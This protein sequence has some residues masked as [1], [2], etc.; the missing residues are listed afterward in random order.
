MRTSKFTETQIVA[1]L[2]QADAGVSVKD[3]CRQVGISTATYYQWKSKDGGP[4]A[5][6][7]RRVKELESE[8]AK[9]KRMY[10]EL[11][12]DNAAMKDLIAKKL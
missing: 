9:L 8:N 4:E 7:L 1:T 2:K 3:I 12:L 6:E 11:A 10:A 5:S